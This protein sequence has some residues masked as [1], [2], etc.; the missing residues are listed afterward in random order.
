MGKK[1]FVT[2]SKY[3][4]ISSGNRVNVILTKIESNHNTLTSTRYYSYIDDITD[5]LYSIKILVHSLMY[6]VS[7]I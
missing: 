2:F 3:S 4:T 5:Q 6:H 1:K 7:M